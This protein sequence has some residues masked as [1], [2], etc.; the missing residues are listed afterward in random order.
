M[1]YLTETCSPLDTLV[2][3]DMREAEEG[4]AT[5]DGAVFKMIMQNAVNMRGQYIQQWD[6]LSEKC[7]M[8]MPNAP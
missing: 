6:Q 2:A 4:R 7:C 8:S 5:A 1:W 3:A